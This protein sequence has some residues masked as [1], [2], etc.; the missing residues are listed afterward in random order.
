MGI[1]FCV[2]VCFPHAYKFPRRTERGSV[3]PGVEL[4]LEGS[5]PPDMFAGNWICFL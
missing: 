2:Y 1:W 3:T 4:Y 5:E